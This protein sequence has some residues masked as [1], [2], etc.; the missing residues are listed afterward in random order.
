MSADLQPDELESLQAENIGPEPAVR[1]VLADTKTVV[2]VQ[3]LPRK[4][5]GTRTR[6][7]GTTPQL[8]L[9]A[10]H[11]RAQVLLIA[12]AAFLVAFSSASAQ[13]PSTMAAWPANVPFPITA[14]VPVWAAAATATVALTIV[15]EMWATGE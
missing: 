7:I 1:V 2:R 12:S 14:D 15:T 5:G 9:S 3:V 4:Q 10:D 13:D 6:T 8:I 11:R